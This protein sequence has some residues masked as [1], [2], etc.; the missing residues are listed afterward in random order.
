MSYI[1]DIKNKYPPF[2][3]K[4]DEQ[5]MIRYHLDNND[6]KGMRDELVLRNV[7]LIRTL[8]KS[9]N[10]FYTPDEIASYGME[11]LIKAS[12]TYD[13]LKGNRF[14]SYA[15]KAIVTSFIK[16]KKEK[17]DGIDKHCVS[18]DELYDKDDEDKTQLSN[19]L[20]NSIPE[21]YKSIKYFIPKLENK[22][23]EI[24]FNKLIESS[25]L[26]EKEISVFKNVVLACKSQRELSREYKCTPENIR[27][28]Y[29]RAATK[30]RRY[31]H[32]AKFGEFLGLKF[33]DLKDYRICYNKYTRKTY[34]N[35]I[36]TTVNPNPSYAYDITA[37]NNAKDQFYKDLR[38]KTKE[39]FG[40]RNIL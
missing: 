3:T 8:G 27:N 19:M 18:F 36:I 17:R 31:I 26:T 2:K 1:T 7:G 35:V 23:S 21:E 11:G 39:L 22:D 37:Y 12:N 5:A 28:T 38:R 10:Q 40:S 14:S 30:L 32:S 16:N 20:E 33:P 9:W 13:Y 4:E 29:T 6:E 24:F 34:S 25:N 15:G